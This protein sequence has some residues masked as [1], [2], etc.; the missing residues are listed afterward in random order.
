VISKNI[1][2][3]AKVVFY[4]F[5]V[6]LV[7]ELLGGPV[8]MWHFLTLMVIG[9]LSFLRRVLPE[10]SLNPSAIWFAGICS[11]FLLWSGQRF[12][13]WL[14][15]HFRGRPA[16]GSLWPATW[17]W[18]WTVGLY[19]GLWLLFLAS[20]SVT[21]VSHQI[22]WLVRSGQPVIENRLS[23]EFYEIITKAHELKIECEVSDWKSP[24]VRKA[25]E[26]SLGSHN[27]RDEAAFERWHVVFIDNKAGLTEAVFISYRDPELRRKHGYRR[28]TPAGTTVGPADRLPDDIRACSAKA[29][30][31]A[32]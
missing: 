6:F 5:L 30:A 10:V 15:G 14:Y 7:L 17:P 28:I 25:C 16:A 4:L 21:G 31:T 18:R 12:C 2:F 3:T 13:A 1:M 22:G 9:W 23:R 11:G 24:S 29:E 20:M 8:P 19:C 32:K 26:K 27:R